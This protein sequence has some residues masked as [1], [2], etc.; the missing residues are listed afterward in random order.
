MVSFGE[1]VAGAFKQ[2]FCFVF[3]KIQNLEQLGSKV[4]PGAGS[5]GVPPAGF[6]FN[7]VC[8]KPPPQKD[9]PFDG[10]QCDNVDYTIRCAFKTRIVD[11]ATNYDDTNITVTGDAAILKG[12]ITNVYATIESDKS[13]SAYAITRGTRYRLSGGFF[14]GSGRLVEA[15]VVNLSVRRT[16]GAADLCGNPPPVAPPFSPDGDKYPYKFEYDGPNGEQYSFPITIAFGYFGVNVNGELTIPV[17]FNF[18]LNPEFNFDFKWNFNTGKPEPYLPPKTPG[19][20]KP[21]GE[22]SEPTPDPTEPPA[23]DPEFPPGPDPDDEEEPDT[24]KLLRAVIVTVFDQDGSTG[25]LFQSP[26]PD[27]ALPNFGYI[28]FK[29]QYGRDVFFLPDQAVKN[30]RC[31]IPCEWQYG[32]IG[33]VGTPRPGIQWRLTPVYVEQVYRPDFPPDTVVTP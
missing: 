5:I 11:I 2:G 4:I 21:G 15:E 28:N 25:R 32:A 19:K 9:S 30:Q 26:A 6:I 8:D 33:V 31:F 22:E 24:R 3:D 10:G 16:N 12:P 23:P 18:D 17:N 7:L 20:P 14:S 27:I 1:A 13:W 29:V